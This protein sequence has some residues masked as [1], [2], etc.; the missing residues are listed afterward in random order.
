MNATLV[1]LFTQW[2]YDDKTIKEIDN[3]HDAIINIKTIEEKIIL[4]TFFTVTKA[5]WVPELHAREIPFKI[6]R[7][8]GVEVYVPKIQ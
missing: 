7:P 6:V 4:R 2:A 3:I 8:G 5:T 1:T